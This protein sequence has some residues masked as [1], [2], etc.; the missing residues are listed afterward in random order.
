MKIFRRI[1]QHLLSEN[2][3]TRYLLYAFGEIV[4]VVIG[5]LIALQINNQN[6]IQKTRVKELHYLNNIKTDLDLNMAELDK[7][8]AKRN[9]CIVSANIIID[10]FEGTPITDY[11][12]FNEHCIKIY[13]WQKF[14]QNNNTF[15][16]LTNSGNLA[17]ISNDSIKNMLLNLESL[18]KV[19][20]C[21]EEH[22]RFDTETLI[23]EPLYGLMDLNPLV[24]NYEYR[25]TG[26]RSGKNLPLNE[27]TFRE[28][29]KNTKLKN[30]FVMTVLEFSVINKM[31]SDMKSMSEQLVHIIDREI[32]KG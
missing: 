18:Y 5:I 29:F 1:R 2:K 7:Y 23:Y 8:I 14:Y 6:D 28:Y 21:E 11:S 13:S 31:L 3:I 9:S 22:F 30:G 24:L 10:H 32:A 15:L 16:E 25:V 27:D 17:L 19:M 4:L 12:E 20:K 26:G